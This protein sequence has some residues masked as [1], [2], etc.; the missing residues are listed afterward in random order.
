M[1]SAAG[2]LLPWCRDD[3]SQNAWIWVHSALLVQILV[4]CSKAVVLL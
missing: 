3:T 4:A 2:K 1:T